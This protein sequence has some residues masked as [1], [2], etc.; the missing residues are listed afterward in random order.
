MLRRKARLREVR[1]EL[2]GFRT[3]KID[4]VGIVERASSRPESEDD[5]E[6]G[7]W[8]MFSENVDR[9]DII[10]AM[11]LS[12]LSAHF[13]FSFVL[14]DTGRQSTAGSGRLSDNGAQL[15]ASESTAPGSK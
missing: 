14:S 13:S 10:G 6:R 8:R 12:S 5:T 3:A 7:R 15:Q 1:A 2:C 11:A 9:G 4:D